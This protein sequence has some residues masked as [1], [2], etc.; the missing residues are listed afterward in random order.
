MINI[1]ETILHV[2]ENTFSI[3]RNMMFLIVQAG[4]VFEGRSD[5]VRA[6]RTSK[7]WLLNSV[8]NTEFEPLINP[9][10]KRW[11]YSVWECPEFVI[12]QL[13][14]TWTEFPNEEMDYCNLISLTKDV[15][16][17]LKHS[18][19]YLSEDEK[20]KVTGLGMAYFNFSNS[21]VSWFERDLFQQLVNECQQGVDCNLPQKIYSRYKQVTILAYLLGYAGAC[22][23]NFGV[24]EHNVKQKEWCLFCFR[25]AMIR[26]KYCAVHDTTNENKAQFRAGKKLYTTMSKLYP[27][28]IELWTKHRK[29][30]IEIEGRS[31]EINDSFTTTATPYHWRESLIQWVNKSPVLATHLSVKEIDSLS[32]WKDAVIFLRRKFNNLHERSFH[33]EAVRS[34]LYMAIDWFEVEDKF[35]V[36]SNSTVRRVSKSPASSIPTE[37]QI[38]QLCENKSGIRKSE[39]ARILKISPQA[40][41]QMIRRT[42]SLHKYF[43]SM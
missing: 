21:F 24:P 37:I 12:E 35:I 36:N 9:R 28:E 14:S 15:R 22:F 32:N 17:I 34:W 5:G 18:S 1:D 25:R 30:I 11:R 38:A 27:S 16:N 33:F 7:K 2:G 10:L 4:R 29:K 6:E 43:G 31:N 41:G 40:V 26:S 19:D 42:P 8:L 39:I 20:R 13:E 3:M 23:V